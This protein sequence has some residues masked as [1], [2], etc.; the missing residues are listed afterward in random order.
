MI[1]QQAKH[2]EIGCLII[3]VDLRC[4]FLKN[5]GGK[6]GERIEWIE[7]FLS[8]KCFETTVGTAKCIPEKCIIYNK[9]VYAVDSTKE[10]KDSYWYN[11][12]K[13]LL[14]EF[15]GYKCRSKEN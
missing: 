13:D 11:F 15:F 1:C 4:Q 5:W 3:L 2:L 7:N 9:K 14:L 10:E 8:N 12:E 6:M